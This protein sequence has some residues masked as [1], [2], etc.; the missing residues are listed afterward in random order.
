MSS[1]DV[2]PVLEPLRRAHAKGRLA[3][4]FL[5][6]GSPEGDGRRLAE[7]LVQLLFCDATE[8][9]CGACDGCMRVARKDHPDVYWLE[10]M[11]KSRIFSVDQIRELNAN[12]GR[13]SYVGSWKA[14][15]L[16]FADRMKTEAMNALLKTM[17]EPPGRTLLLLVTDQ[18]QGLLPTIVS[19]CQRINLGE[20]ER[21]PDN[22]WRAELEAW[23]A[24]AGAR[25][26]LTAMARAS[27]LLRLLERVKAE[28][29]EDEK[30]RDE[31]EEGGEG[32]SEDEDENEHEYDEAG[33]VEWRDREENVARD[34]RV[35][36][37][38][39]R[40]IK[41]RT[42]MLRTIQLWQRDVLACKMGAAESVLHFPD[43]S[44]ILRKQAA[45][46]EVGALFAR[47]RAVDEA[48]SR[49]GTNLNALMVLDAMVRAGV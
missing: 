19:R 29:E 43:Q 26:P 42:A 1:P 6:V 14:A 3:H 37:I 22:G 33:A 32:V 20:R 2:I 15:I 24:E 45:E 47:I 36:R 21:P 46:C 11:K 39:S 44:E 8:K 5:I 38:A 16:L 31:A 4:A 49:L 30:R 18:M 40:L 34:V 35:A 41:E 12:L 13:T 10:P 7:A 27:R 9:P 28:I 23:L 17:E 48:Q 25:G